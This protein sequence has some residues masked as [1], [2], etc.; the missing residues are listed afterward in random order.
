MQDVC[1]RW[2]AGGWIRKGWVCC[3]GSASQ[4]SRS[5]P[6]HREFGFRHSPPPTGALRRCRCGDES[7]NVAGCCRCGDGGAA[8]VLPP[9]CASSRPGYPLPLQPA[10]Q[11]LQREGVAWPQ[12]NRCSLPSTH[13]CLSP[14]AWPSSNDSLPSPSPPHQ[15]A[16][17]NTAGVAS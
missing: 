6:P 15:F 14:R 4:T 16:C 13:R 11:C 9:S 5:S 3:G 7:H 12:K 8:M 10:A 1:K 17:G 2:A